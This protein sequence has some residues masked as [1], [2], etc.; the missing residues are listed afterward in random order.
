MQLKLAEYK[1][2]KFYRFLE[3]GKDFGYFG[4]F[5]LIKPNQYWGEVKYSED[6][7]YGKQINKDKTDLLNRFNGLFNSRTYGEGRFVL[8]IKYDKHFQD[9]IICHQVGIGRDFED[10]P[11]LDKKYSLYGS[12]SMIVPISSEY[13]YIGNLHE[14]PELYEK[15]R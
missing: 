9:D 14:N 10:L 12:R 8:I 1:N 13:G 15:I 11:I 3:L 6:C 2:G 4:D 7:L 5:I